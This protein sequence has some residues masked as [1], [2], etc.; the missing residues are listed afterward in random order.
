MI[1]EEKFHWERGTQVIRR[2][3]LFALDNKVTFAE[4]QALP[5]KRTTKKVNEEVRK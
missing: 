2:D 1:R 4:L 3:V 5:W